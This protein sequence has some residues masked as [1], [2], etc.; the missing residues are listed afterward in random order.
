MHGKQYLVVIMMLSL[1]A[2]SSLQFVHADGGNFHLITVYWGDSQQAEASPGTTETLTVVLRYELD[3]AFTGLSA[4]L[5]VPE[6]FEAVGGGNTVTVPYTGPI[7]SGSIIVLKFPVYLSEDCVLGSHTAVLTLEYKRSRYVNSVDTLDIA[8]EVT[9]QPEVRLSALEDTVYEG[10]QTIWI[11]VTNTGDAV[12]HA[13]EMEDAVASGVSTEFPA[14]TALGDLDPGTNVQTP[15]ELIVPQGA[16]GTVIPVTIDVSYFG[17]SNIFYRR[18]EKLHLLVKSTP[19]RPLTPTLAPNELTIGARTQVTI[20]LTNAGSHPV[21]NLDLTLS[22]D[23]TVKILSDQTLY[24]YESLPPTDSIPVPLEIYVPAT[25]LS[26]T[27]SISL[28]VTYFDEAVWLERSERYTLNFLLRGLIDISL[29]DQVVIPTEPRVGSPFSATI[30]VTNIGTSVAYAAA[31]LPELENLPLKTFGPKSVYIGN[32]DL[33]L[34]TTFT[35]NLQLD[36]TTDAE[37]LLPVT[38]TYMDNLRKPYAVVFTIPVTIAPEANGSSGTAPGPP[39]SPFRGTLILG[40]LAAIAAISIVV[41]WRRK[42]SRGEQ[43][44]R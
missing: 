33:N 9:G 14:A 4:D 39:I 23:A 22:P 38:L 5:Q 40:G 43:W 27:A 2:L 37:I 29:T 20:T 16:R 41:L 3:Y 11:E 28:Q 7:S 30:T 17:P 26:P 44:P 6:G 34:P 21:S 36:N 8:V 25:T 31:A 32:I 1:L 15:L 42:R 10:K 18:T 24:H 13:I 12:A 19:G 35:I